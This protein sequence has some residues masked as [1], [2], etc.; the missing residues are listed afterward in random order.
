MGD[1]IGPVSTGVGQFICK[2]SEKIPADMN[3]YAANKAAIVQGLEQDRLRIEQPLFRDSV[4][5]DLKKRGKIQMNQA[6]I[7]HIQE[8]YQG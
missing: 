2:V 3:Q 4:L 7:S 5:N 8:R 6:A 1:I